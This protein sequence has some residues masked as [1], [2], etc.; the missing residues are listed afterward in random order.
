LKSRTS[1][2]TSGTIL[3]FNRESIYNVTH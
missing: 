1:S 3:F 2:N